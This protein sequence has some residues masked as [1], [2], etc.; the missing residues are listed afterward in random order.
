MSAELLS[1]RPIDGVTEREIDLLL[2]LALHASPGFRAFL[3]SKTA[4]PGD[5]EFLGAWRGVYDNLGECDLLVLVRDAKDRRVAIMIE[6]KIDAS[7]QPGQASRYRERGERGC[8]LERWDRFITCLCTPKAFAEPIARG[9]AWDTILTYEEIEASLVVQEDAFAPFVRGALRQ[10]ADKQRSGG[11]VVSHQASAF[12]AQYRRLQREEF[13]ELK[14]TA[15]AEVQSANDPWPRFAAG[16]LPPRVKLEHKPWKGC[17]DLTFQDMKFEDLWSRL[18][19]LL[20]CD[21]EVR[22]TARSAAVRAT[23]PPLN[24]MQ[25]FEPQIEAVRTAFRAAEALL[26][27]WPDIRVAA[28]FFP[29]LSEPPPRSDERAPFS[30]CGC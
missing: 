6:D 9:E 22:R 19:G 7:F 10:A 30:K 11:F 26:R 13:P 12:W 16:M 25:P 27:L 14:M 2:L 18:E 5:F 21:F 3:A 4:G 29:P 17:V 20:P 23:V 28:G 24:A 8:A 1:R 15:L